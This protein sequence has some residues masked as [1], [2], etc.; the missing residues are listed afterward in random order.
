MVLEG[1]GDLTAAEPLC[2][3]AVAMT[4]RLFPGDNFEVARSLCNLARVLRERGDLAGSQELLREAS[5]MLRR[6]GMQ[7]Q[8]PQREQARSEPAVDLVARAWQLLEPASPGT[9]RDPAGALALAKQAVEATR[10]LEAGPLQ[11]LAEALYA[12]GDRDEAASKM[13]RAMRAW[14]ALKPAEREAFGK[15]DSAWMQ[16]RLQEYQK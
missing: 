6:L 16:A 10:G 14:Q 15:R 7:V 2:R 9:Q 8:A 5:E 12:T 11:V 4:R 1:R 3:E 13:S